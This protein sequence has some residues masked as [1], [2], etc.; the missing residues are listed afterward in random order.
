MTKAEDLRIV[1]LYIVLRV[2]KTSR[3]LIEGVE[4]VKLVPYFVL[5]KKFGDIY[6][7]VPTSK[8]QIASNVYEN[9]LKEHQIVI[10]KMRQNNRY[11]KP[12]HL[13]AKL[14]GKSFTMEQLVQFA[15]EIEKI[16]S[17]LSQKNAEKQ[18]EAVCNKMAKVLSND[19]AMSF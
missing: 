19:N 12:I 13:S 2:D 16:N 11:R 7:V 15:E 8:L 10:N 4:T 1:K 14:R 6:R 5:V 18:L 3:G 9:S 17:N